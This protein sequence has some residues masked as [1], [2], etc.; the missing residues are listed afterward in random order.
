MK[1]YF[2]AECG[3]YDF[4]YTDACSECQEPIPEDSWSD[5]PDE[6]LTQLDY[7][8]EFDLPNCIPGWEYEVIRLTSFAEGQAASDEAAQDQT[9]IFTEHLLN[10]MGDKGWELV[11]IVPLDGKD[12]PSYGVFK[13]AWLDEFEE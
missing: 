4:V 3:A 13:R 10:R 6:D 11:N 8:E 1:I 9:R 12:G 7:I 2:C 5:L